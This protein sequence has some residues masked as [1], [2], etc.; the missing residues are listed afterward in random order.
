[1]AS[2]PIVGD[3]EAREKKRYTESK[4]YTRK[5]FKG[6][7]NKGNVL[8]AV[9]LPPPPPPSAAPSTATTTNGNGDNATATV[10]AATDNNK[11]NSTVENGN[12]GA[13]DNGINVSVQSLAPVTVP[14]DGNSAQPQE[15]SRLLENSRLE[16]L[17]DDT[18]SLNRPQDEP[19]SLHVEQDN[20]PGMRDSSPGNCAPKQGLDNRVKI[21]LATRSKQEMRELRRRLE[22]ELYTV[23]NLVNRIEE[24]QGLSGGYG[25]SSM[26][27]DHRID[28]EGG[29][30]CPPSEVVSGA[31]PR[32]PTRSLHKL[33]LS[34]LENS[35][36]VGEIVEKEKR[37]PKA[38][39]FYRN[40]EFLL[41]KDKFPPAESNKKSKLNGKKHGAGEMGHGHGMGSKLLKSCSSL[42]EKLMKHKHGW[43][44]NAPVDVEGLGLH[45]YFTIITHP[46][47]L[48]TVKSR[49]NQNWYKSPKEFAEDVRLT[50]RNAM[51]YNPKGQDV[52]VMAEQLSKLFEDRW[53]IIES[54]YNREMRYG[55]DYGPAIP[56]PSPLSRKAP[57]FRP[58]PIDMRWIL[59]RSESMTQP[60]KILSITPSSRTPAPKKPKAKD[61]HKRDM[62]YEEKQKLSTNLQSLPSEKLDAIVQIIKKRNSALSQH[63]DEIEVDI[64]SVDAETLWELDRFVTNYKKSLS[65]NKR[66]AEL[67]IQA[68]ARAEQNAQ[69][70]SQLPVMVEVQKETQADERN[71]PSSIPVEGQIQVDNGSKTSSSSSSTSDSGSSS[72]DSDSDS[73]SSSGSDAGSQRT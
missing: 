21:S 56:T 65:K 17:S 18:S 30:E 45:D 41:A 27:V 59:D 15:N 67:A 72:S 9:P 5:A 66:K 14:E 73:S 61:P 8:N 19:S 6:P 47:D 3:D 32:E 38:N 64:D 55:L 23:R 7:K 37:T 70:K 29:I 50:F 39:Q 33:S 4:V 1:M 42:L 36:G 28:N 12:D 20:G 13:K 71:V 22:S 24:K 48:G 44:F 63:D 68:R 31:V 69:L 25:N 34:V 43:V 51:T 58:P 62:T 60:P 54:N 46:M 16:A 49:L 40:S 53:A 2:G 57:A 26:L 35:Q 11:D 52:H 10:A